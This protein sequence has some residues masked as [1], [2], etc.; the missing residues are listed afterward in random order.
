MLD[1]PNSNLD[2]EGDE[3]LSRAIMGVRARGGIVIVIAH[4]PSAIASVDLL[5]MMNQGRA[6][7]FGPK[8]EVLSRGLQRDGVRHASAQG[9]ARNGSGKIMSFVHKIVERSRELIEAASRLIG[10]APVSES[11]RSIRRTWWPVLPSSWCS[12]AASAAGPER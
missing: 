6:V 2:S 10:P 12:P 3:A 8:D 5:L 11:G 4:R 7:A 1:E 9:R